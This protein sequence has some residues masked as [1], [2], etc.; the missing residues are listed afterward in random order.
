MS[1]EQARGALELDHR[2]DI[3][4]AGI[5]LYEMLTATIPFGGDNYNQVLFAIMEGAYTPASQLRPGL[6]AHIDKIISKALAPDPEQRFQSAKEMRSVLNDTLKNPKAANRDV[7]P[8]RKVGPRTPASPPTA[9]RPPLLDEIDAN[10]QSISDF[11]ALDMGNLV[12]LDGSPDAPAPS[13]PVPATAAA[14]AAAAVATQEPLTTVDNNAFAPPA[15]EALP[16]LVPDLGLAAPASG[17]SGRAAARAVQREGKQR[18][19]RKL[20]LELAHHVNRAPNQAAQARRS[21]HEG[22]PLAFAVFV[23]ALLVGVIVIA[24]QQFLF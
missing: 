13:A 3:W 6:G 24:G 10:S 14:A 5:V 12:S 16:D 21:A 8:T 7:Q 18:I 4:A 11:S 9:A 17:V 22:T 1:P 23:A 19:E 15:E 20:E 2:S